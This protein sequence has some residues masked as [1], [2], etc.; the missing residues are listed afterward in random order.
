LPGRVYKSGCVISKAATL[1]AVNEL[2]LV[3]VRI[4]V[5]APVKSNLTEKLM[6]GIDGIV[7]QISKTIYPHALKTTYEKAPS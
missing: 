4:R 5:G 2:V 1:V 3:S 7:T 6:L